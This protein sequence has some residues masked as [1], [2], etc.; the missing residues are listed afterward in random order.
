MPYTDKQ[1]AAHQR[2][3]SEG[4][5][6]AVELVSRKAGRTPGE[7]RLW[8]L[9]EADRG[10]RARGF[11]LRGLGLSVVAAICPPHVLWLV[12]G[13]TVSVIGYFA[14]GRQSERLLGGEARC[15]G[16]GA[17]Q[18]LDPEPVEFPFLHFCT[19]CGVRCSV[20]RA[21]APERSGGADAAGPR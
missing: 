2:M 11:L 17:V 10:R 20:E 9:S 1:I 3:M 7:V 15:P 21:T 8:R 13:I 18:Y 6:L 19:E 12:V 16:C 4:E 5:P 14:R